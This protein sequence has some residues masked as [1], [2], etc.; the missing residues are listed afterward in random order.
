MSI[1]LDINLVYGRIYSLLS[2]LGLRSDDY[3]FS[4]RKKL[5]YQRIKFLIFSLFFSFF[6]Q[7]YET[8]SLR[9]PIIWV[10]EIYELLSHWIELEK[11]DLIFIINVKFWKRLLSLTPLGS[12]SV[13]SSLVYTIW[14]PY[15]MGLNLEFSLI[16]LNNSLSTFVLSFSNSGCGLAA[17]GHTSMA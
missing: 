10:S 9:A 12:N 6:S 14:F 5:F 4:R 2:S 7:L 15:F 16:L 8:P 1:L 11:K 13:L 17:E 3:A